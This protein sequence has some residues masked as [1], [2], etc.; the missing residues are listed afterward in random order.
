MKNFGRA[1]E[2]GCGDGRFTRDHLIKKYDVVDMFD[3]DG[4]A[5]ENVKEL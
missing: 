2:V 5:I 3:I 4:P 1:I